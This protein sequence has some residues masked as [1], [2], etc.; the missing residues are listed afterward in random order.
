MGMAFADELDSAIHDL[1]RQ[2]CDRLIVDL[3][4]NIGGSLG[5]ARLA[6]YM[7]GGQMT[8]GHSLTPKRLRSGYNPEELPRVPMPASR[9]GLVATLGKYAFRDK[10]VMLLT[11]G[12]GPQPFHGR[13]ALL[14]NEWT[15]SAAEMLANFAAENKLATIVGQK[16]R[17]MFSVQQISNSTR[18]I[19]CGC[20]CSDGFLRRARRLKGMAWNPT[21]PSKFHLKH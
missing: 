5:F 14:V 21:L 17:G 8:I 11:Q 6:S 1:K 10:S 13:I 3:R 9:L 12:L 2:G 7:C 16:T 20:R 19:G 15:N 18:D 4:G